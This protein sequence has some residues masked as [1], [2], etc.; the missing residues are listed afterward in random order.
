HQVRDSPLPSGEG[1]VRAV[2][3][4]RPFLPS[5][6]F[7]RPLPEG[8][9]CPHR[10]AYPVYSGGRAA[11]AFAGSGIAN[12]TTWVALCVARLPSTATTMYCLPL[13]RYVMGTP[14]GGPGCVGVS[15][16]SAPVFLS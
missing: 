12:A 2:F 14:V 16:T 13:Y 1:W 8:E 3:D 7:A 5:P 4:A 15:Q 11:G 10:H 6:R 9:G